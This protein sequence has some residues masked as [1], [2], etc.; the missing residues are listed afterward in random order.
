MK[1]VFQTFDIQINTDDYSW[2]KEF[3]MIFIYKKLN[4]IHVK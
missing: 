3:I 2:L 4:M 1:E